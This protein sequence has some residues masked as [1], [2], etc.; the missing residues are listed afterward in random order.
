MSTAMLTVICVA[1]LGVLGLIFGLVLGFAAKK[2]A[3]ETDPREEAIVACLP[4]A[5]CGGCGFPGCSGYAA[6]V[7]KGEAA[8]NRCVAGGAAVAAQV[9]EIM[10]V[11]AETAARSV[12]MVRC[13]GSSERARKKYDYAGIQDCRSAAL[14][15]GGG[16][17]ECA[18]GCLGFGSCVAACNF[19]AMHIVDGVARVDREKCVG[20]M[21]CA[22]A[23]PK[24]LIIKVPYDGQVTVPCASTEKGAEVRK[25]CDI[26]CI[27]CRICEKTCEQDAI[28]VVDNVAVI[29]YDKCISC[30]KCA[31]KCPR[32]L[33]EDRRVSAAPAA[34]SQTA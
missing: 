14:L 6:A 16:P 28:H 19:D 22:E 25:L 33:I 9:A 10:G 20:C 18:F 23:C 8:T 7:V 26:G 34:D 30:G 15:P 1:V 5:N 31:E 17:K 4:G 27:G 2:F 24:H 29:D 32:H 13:S 21:A 11:S 12:A 3:V